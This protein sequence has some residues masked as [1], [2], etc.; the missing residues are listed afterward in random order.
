M[1]NSESERVLVVL[2]VQMLA[3][4]SCSSIE[5]SERQISS[6]DASALESIEMPR[7]VVS[8]T[9]MQDNKRDFTLFETNRRAKNL[10]AAI[11]RFLDGLMNFGI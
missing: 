5:G 2:T 3:L 1:S 10:L 7:R 6:R 4:S 11:L 9:G 8:H